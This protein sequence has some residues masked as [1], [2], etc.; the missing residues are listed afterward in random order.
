M[1]EIKPLRAWRYNNDLSKDI[2]AL[3][4]P[5]FD[6]VSEKQRQSLYQNEFNSI[7]ISVPKPPNAAIKAESLLKKWK[8]E[9]VIVQDDKPGIYVYYQYFNLA[10]AKSLCRKGFVCNIRIYD[11]DENVILRHENTIPKSVNDRIELLEKT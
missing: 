4:S 5:L 7:H 8:A 2:E 6:V 1:A 3:T 10:G 11:W 9:G